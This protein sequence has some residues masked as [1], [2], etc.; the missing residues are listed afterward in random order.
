[1]STNCPDMS[2]LWVLVA[3]L[4]IGAGRH[5]TGAVPP[6]ARWLRKLTLRRKKATT[7]RPHSPPQ[8]RIDRPPN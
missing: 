6:L 3:R 1:M 4:D 5:P 7:L 2:N 8:G